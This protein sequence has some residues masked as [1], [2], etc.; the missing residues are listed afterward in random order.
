MDKKTNLFPFEGKQV[1]VVD[2]DGNVY[3]GEAYVS[4][5]Y[6]LDDICYVRLPN[7]RGDRVSIYVDE[8][9]SIEIIG[10]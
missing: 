2:I 9:A 3:E 1:K 5:E 4:T 8:I 6:E 7:A 10:E